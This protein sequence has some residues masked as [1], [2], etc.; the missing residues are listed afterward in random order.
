MGYYT[1]FKLEVK[2]ANSVPGL[3]KQGEVE[4]EISSK[5]MVIRIDE[6]IKKIE[7]NND[8]DE[9]QS[10]VEKSLSKINIEVNIND[11]IPALRKENECAESAI[12]D[13]GE[14][15]EPLKWYECDKDMIE[16]SK[17]YPQHLFI[18]SGDG[19]ESDD[20]WRHYFFNGKII[21][22]KAEIVFKEPDYSELI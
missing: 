18:L 20:F 19:E 1:K 22:T 14:T 2:N 3:Q 8:D 13:F 5:D 21:Q 9:L 10:V 12:N 4:Q 11:I 6:L 17:K 7:N 15:E 16:F